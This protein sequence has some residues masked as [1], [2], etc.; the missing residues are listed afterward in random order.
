M[1]QSTPVKCED[2]FSRFISYNTE[3]YCADFNTIM[4]NILIEQAQHNEDF[5][6]KYLDIKLD[7]V[8][9]EARECFDKIKS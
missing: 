7:D 6:M 9:K 8:K 4:Y 2:D 1:K 5:K 3:M